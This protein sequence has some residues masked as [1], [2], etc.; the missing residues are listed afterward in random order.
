[1]YDSGV[2]VVGTDTEVGKTYHAAQFARYLT[3]RGVQ[4]GVYKPVASG[5]YPPGQSDAE[6]LHGAA[7]LENQVERV[8]P[9]SFIAPLAPPMAAKQMGRRVSK[10]LLRKG[11]K[12]WES[13]C[14]FFIVE[15]AGGL[16]SPIAESMTV[17]DFAELLQLPV[18]LVAAN[19]LGVVNHTLLSLEALASRRLEIR[20][21]VLN[22]IPNPKSESLDCSRDSNRELLAEFAGSVPLT[23]S[24]AELFPQF[25]SD[26]E[27]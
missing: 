17:V 13:E 7:G 18:V 9:Q 20:G 24:I 10:S 11:A 26:T 15:G 6:I 27:I 8:C 12:W 21:V 5:T 25:S 14:E 4:V 1:M 22:T 3:A 2:F 23:D 16:L 19:R